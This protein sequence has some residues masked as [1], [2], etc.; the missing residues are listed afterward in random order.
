MSKLPKR[1][2]PF[3]FVA[4]DRNTSTEFWVI[5]HGESEWNVTGQYQGQA[6]VPLSPTG[7]KQARELA[8]RLAGLEFD[9]IYTSDLIRASST[10][11]TVAR[12]LSKG[13]EIQSLPALREIHVGE[14]SGLN[15]HQI[16]EQYGDYIAALQA[17]PWATK[18]PGGESMADLYERCAE[19]FNQ[20]RSQHPGER[21]LIFTHG[22]VIR[23]AVG[24]VLGGVPANAWARLSVSNTSI[25]RI[26][27]GEHS[28][29][30]LSFNDDAHLE[31]WVEMIKSDTVLGQ[32]Q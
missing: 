21:V 9:A 20:I 23:V 30:L 19:A 18:R 5:R 11:H 1:L 7:R 2:A 27:L 3:G 29:T 8:H 13:L 31:D 24:L 10:A 28:G 12:K 22:G 26:L 14:L 32:S 15:K 16:R 6:D 25:T 4:P 17:N